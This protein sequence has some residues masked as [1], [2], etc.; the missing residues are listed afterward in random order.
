MPTPRR[1]A[2]FGLLSAFWA[3]P[4]EARVTVTFQDT[5]NYSDPDQRVPVRA[6]LKTHLE[7]LGAR[8]LGPDTDLKVT[9]VDVRLAGQYA[10]WHTPPSVRVMSDSTWPVITVRYTLLRNGRTIAAREETISDQYYLMKSR[11]VTAGQLAYEKAMLDD[12][13]RERFGRRQPN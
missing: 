13:F 8:Y 6:V 3:V 5:G 9:V 2:F 4:A 10:W 1:L 11:S 12:W 7:R